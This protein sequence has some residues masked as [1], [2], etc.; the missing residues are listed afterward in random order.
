MSKIT[1]N[2]VL[3]VLR[4]VISLTTK[5]VRLIYSIIDL[6]DD[7]CINASAPRPEWMQ[8]L[9]SAINTIESVGSHLTVVEDEIY[10][11]SVNVNGK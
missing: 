8:V 4:L 11:D 10:N 2:A 7:G 1:I 5:V 6:V 9:V 3:T